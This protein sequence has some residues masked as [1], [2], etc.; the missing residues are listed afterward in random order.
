MVCGEIPVTDEESN[1]SDKNIWLEGELGRSGLKDARLRKRF[2]N[3]LEQLWN[4]L[5]QTIPFACQI[6]HFLDVNLIKKT[7]FAHEMKTSRSQ[8]DRLLDPENTNISLKALV[9]TA[10][11][12]GKHVEVRLV[13]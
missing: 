11:A 13:D 4:G 2:K 7:E 10:N 12:M 9:S 8:L 6:Q 3:L 1:N 5:G